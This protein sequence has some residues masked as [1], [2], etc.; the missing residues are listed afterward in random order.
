MLVHFVDTQLRLQQIQ[1]LAHNRKFFLQCISVTFIRYELQ[2]FFFR[3]IL[4]TPNR[5]HTSNQKSEKSF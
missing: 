1:T 2:I 3:Y 5:N 4:I